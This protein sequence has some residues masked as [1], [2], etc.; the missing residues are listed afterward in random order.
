MPCKP[1]SVAYR[2]FTLIEVVVV[3][4]IIA[5][6]ALMAI[7]NLWGRNARAQIVESVPLFDMAKAGVLMTYRGDGK[8][9][10]N[11]A[12]AGLPPPDKIVGNYVSAVTVRDGAVT[13]TFGNKVSGHIKGKKLS[14]RPA[15]VEDAPS[16]PI[17]W[18]CGKSA[19]PD[20]MKAAGRDE[21]DVPV[22]ALPINCR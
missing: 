8:F 21:T 15:Y 12:E 6:L 2:G 7:P 4:L 19:V 14:V 18:V 22:E 9:A 16:V 10:A 5:I 20:K 11:N 13:M 1:P 3:M 17:S